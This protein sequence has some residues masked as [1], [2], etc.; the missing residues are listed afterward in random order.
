MG[1][2]FTLLLEG[3]FATDLWACA[4]VAMRSMRSRRQSGPAP[5]SSCNYA[6]GFLLGG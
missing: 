1:R 5:G 2:R 4:T 3:G 6:C